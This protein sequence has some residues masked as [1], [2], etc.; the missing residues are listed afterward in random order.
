[1]KIKEWTRADLDQLRVRERSEAG[2]AIVVIQKGATTL[3]EGSRKD[4][5]NKQIDILF[6]VVKSQAS[7]L[8]R[9]DERL[10][11]LE[12]VAVTELPLSAIEAVE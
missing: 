6:S 9:L 8:E 7:L 4:L 1:M 12:K 10:S 2:R 3:F 5:T 11:H